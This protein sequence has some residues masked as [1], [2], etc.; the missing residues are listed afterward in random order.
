MPTSKSL[1]IVLIVGRNFL[2]SN[3][4]QKTLQ[5]IE[6]KNAKLGQVNGGQYMRTSTIQ[7]LQPQPIQ[8]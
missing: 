1:A 6:E 8:V 2:K 3:C 7:Y 4:Q 5:I